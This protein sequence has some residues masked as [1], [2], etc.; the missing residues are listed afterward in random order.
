MVAMRGGRTANA[1]RAS[2]MPRQLNLGSF[3]RCIS[4]TR[5]FD[6]D[7]GLQLLSMLSGGQIGTDILTQARG[8]SGILEIAG[9]RGGVPGGCG[10]GRGAQCV[11]RVGRL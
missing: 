8:N 2:A 10:V 4:S 6:H 3:M 11:V 9:R 1:L 7:I 5:T